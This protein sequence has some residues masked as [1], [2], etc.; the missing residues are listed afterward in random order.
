MGK[1]CISRSTLC[2]TLHGQTY[3]DLFSMFVAYHFNSNIVFCDTLALQFPLQFYLIALD[4]LIKDACAMKSD[5][6]WEK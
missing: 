2:L 5:C 3:R 1:D 4:K 6:G